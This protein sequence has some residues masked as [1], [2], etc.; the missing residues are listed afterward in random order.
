MIYPTKYGLDVSVEILRD[1][2]TDTAQ[3]KIYA[4]MYVNKEYMLPFSF[5]SSQFTDAK[6]LKDHD[7][8]TCMLKRY[9]TL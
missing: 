9:G 1:T 7:F 3:V 2:E 8:N 6:I 4:P 5:S